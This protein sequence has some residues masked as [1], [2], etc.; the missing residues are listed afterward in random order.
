[1]ASTSSAT[2]DTPSTPEP[3][4]SELSISRIRM[5]EGSIIKLPQPLT[6]NNWITW[7]EH[8]LRLAAVCEIDQYLL[9]KIPRPDQVTD[10]IGYANWGCNDSNACYLLSVNVDEGP[11]IYVERKPTSYDMWQSLLDVYETKSHQTIVTVIRN[12]FHT[13][14]TD[15]DNILDHVITLKKYWEYV[16][17]MDDDDFRISN[18]FFKVILSSSLPES[19]DTFTEP[20]VGIRKGV[21]KNDPKKTISSQEFIGILKEEYICCQGR[22]GKTL[23]ESTSQANVSRRDLA[24]RLSDDL[25]CTHCHL[26]NHTV[27]NCRNIG[28]EPCSICHKYGHDATKCRLNKRKRDNKDT[29]DKKGKKKAKTSETNEGVEDEND[30]EHIVLTS[31]EDENDNA[32]PFDEDEDIYVNEGEREDEDEKLEEAWTEASD[33]DEAFRFNSLGENTFDSTAEDVFNPSNEGQYF[34]F[35]QSNV[36]SQSA[37]NDRLIYYNWL[38]DSATTSHVTN[39]CDTFRTFKPLNGMTVSGVE[40]SKQKLKAEVQSY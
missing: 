26:H 5:R 12:L 31:L 4:N 10:P 25:Y 3:R 13:I 16:N 8:M 20:Y 23:K 9:G 37:I 14:A 39:Q 24:Q 21:D 30:D 29:G 28:K 6:E 22:S 27:A 32:H 34:N 1:M 40:M 11:L 17:L 18:I 33:S 38:A 15:Q 7:H 35:D 2:R 19:W 36:N